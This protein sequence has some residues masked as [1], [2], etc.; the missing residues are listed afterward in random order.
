MGKQNYVNVHFSFPVARFV[1]L[2]SGDSSRTATGE[3]NQKLSANDAKNVRGTTSI[4]ADK[5]EIIS[6]DIFG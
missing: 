6:F 3:R 2:M 1:L 4:E 5:K